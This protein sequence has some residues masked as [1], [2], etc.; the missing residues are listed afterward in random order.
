MNRRR[1]VQRMLTTLA[2]GGAAPSLLTRTARAAK[3]R[4]KVLVVVQLSGG[5]DALN[6][7]VPFRDR[8]YRSVRPNL[9]VP[10]AKVLDLGRDLGLHPALR[11]LLPQW[12]QG[13]LALIP[14][15]GYPDASRSHFVSM[16][17]WHSAD[18]SRKSMQG[19]LGRWLDEQEDP[20]CAV[21]LGLSTP[22]A[23]RGEARQGVALNG[24]EGF[25][26]RLPERALA[27]FEQG[28]RQPRNGPAELARAAMERLLED[29]R[30]VQGLRGYEPA[31]D[32]PRGSFG[33]ALRDVVRMIAGGLDARVYYV[34]LGGFDTHADQL[35]RQPGLLEQLAAGLS[36]LS[37]D[38]K[39]LGRE[40]DVLILGFSEFGRRVE[41]NASGGTDHGKAGLMFALGPGVGGFKGP[42]YNLDDLDDGDLRYQVDFRSVY[43][44]AAAFIGA[45]PEE[46][47]PEPQPLLKLLG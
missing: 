27:R 28:L 4:D 12:E 10:A 24:L 44:G 15:V 18:P 43:A 1:F 16:A 22:L 6:T 35:G 46:L 19:W 42:G 39:A 47:F 17:I 38:L 23:L 30:R 36:A 8:A 33:N 14:A 5:N 41:E 21:N 40:N 25:R 11:A 9:A 13:R 34:A 26:L 45:R 37:Q 2:A 32:Y 20:F 29:T 3:E 31:A 7:L